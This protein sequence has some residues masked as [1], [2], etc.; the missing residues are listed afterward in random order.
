MFLSF[1]VACD[2]LAELLREGACI[3]RLADE[4]IAAKGER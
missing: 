2:D 4:C 3:E 1:F